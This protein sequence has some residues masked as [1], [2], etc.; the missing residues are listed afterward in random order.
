M[1]K[2]VLLLFI[3]LLNA[4][5]A[6]DGL[7]KRTHLAD[8]IASKNNM[9]KSLIK[10]SDFSIMSYQKITNPEK[11]INIYI[12]GDGFAWASA[13]RLSSNPT[14]RNPV[15][16]KLASLDKSANVVYLARPCQ[17]VNLD[18]ETLCQNK[19]W[20]GSK[21]SKLVVDSINQAVDEVRKNAKISLNLIGFSG[22]GAIVAILGAVRSDVASIRTVAG[23]LDHEAF[24]KY[25]GVDMLDDS[26][27]AVDFVGKLKN[28]PQEY[29][30]GS[31][32]KIV[33]PFIAEDFAKKVNSENGCVKVKTLENV[34]HEHGWEIY[35]Q[36]L[37]SKPLL[38]T[39]KDL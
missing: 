23:N 38:C 26:L 5:C 25:H 36:K 21:Y 10:T 7:S 20:H 30:S 8:E 19:Y 15:A 24:N 13:G 4:A 27:N 35:W 33:P 9:Q 12:E 2:I 32:D 3:L 28:I 16:L 14:P 37:I 18:E 31:D 22:G 17:Y 39:S 34:S 29:L 6:F 11:P 1:R